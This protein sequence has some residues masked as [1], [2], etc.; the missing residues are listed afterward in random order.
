MI[1]LE[2]VQ[3]EAVSGFDYSVEAVGGRAFGYESRRRSLSPRQRPHGVL[4]TPR[5]VGELVEPSP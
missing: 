3:A 1:G 4:A 5:G 2:N